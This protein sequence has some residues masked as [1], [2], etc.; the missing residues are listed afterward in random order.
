MLDSSIRDFVGPA[1]DYSYDWNCPDGVPGNG[2]LD[3]ENVAALLRGVFGDTD[4]RR[5]PA[6]ADAEPGRDLAGIGQADAAAQPEPAG[7]S[8]AQERT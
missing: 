4:P 1:R 7:P 3:P 2:A 6:E 5:A 8:G